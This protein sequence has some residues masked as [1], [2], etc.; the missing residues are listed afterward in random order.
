VNCSATVPSPTEY[1]TIKLYKNEQKLSTVIKPQNGNTSF[2][3]VEK[4]VPKAEATYK[5]AAANL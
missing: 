4:P 2:G 1:S 3:R 5:A